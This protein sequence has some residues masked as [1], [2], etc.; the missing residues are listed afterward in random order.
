VWKTNFDHENLL[1][2]FRQ[3][4]HQTHLKESKSELTSPATFQVDARKVVMDENQHD[5]IHVS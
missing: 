5:D 4:P 1:R 3:Q 2:E